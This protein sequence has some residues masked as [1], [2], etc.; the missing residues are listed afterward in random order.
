MV[1]NKPALTIAQQ[2]TQLRKRG[3]SI[4][5]STLAEHFLNN[6]SYYRLAG[7]WWTLQSDRSRHRFRQ[8]ANFQQIVDRYNFDRELRL[9]IMDMIERIEIAVRTKMIYHFSLAYGPH[10]FENKQ[11]VKNSSGWTYSSNQ[12]RKETKKSSEVYLRQFF[13]KYSADKRNPPSWMSLEIVSLGTLSKM[14]GNLKSQLVEKD[15]IAREL[16]LPGQ[17]YLENWLHGIS[18]TR[19]IAAHHSRL[20]QRTLPIKP[21]LPK[22]LHRKWID[23]SGVHKKS[24]YFQISS[25][26]YLLQSISPGNRFSL[27]LSDLF[28]KYPSVKFKEVGFPAN[29]K[30]QPLWK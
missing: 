18:V 4:P 22:K 20:F 28:A 14:F 5:D 15:K 1:Y 11:L 6:V 30:T 17:T 19:N 29:W 27:R 26:A 21:I 9:I 13:K 8:G 25:M 3:L 23:L 12:I 10:W 2:L 7:Y 16:G 24:I